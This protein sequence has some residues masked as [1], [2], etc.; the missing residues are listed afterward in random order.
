MPC[1]IYPKN[2]L[3]L[4]DFYLTGDGGEEVQAGGRKVSACGLLEIHAS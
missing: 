2:N 3:L 4:R 1:N